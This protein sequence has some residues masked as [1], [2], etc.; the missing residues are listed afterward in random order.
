MSSNNT[1]T[2]VQIVAQRLAEIGDTFEQE[3]FA[4]KL[5]LPRRAR[6]RA[7][8]E[9][10]GP[11]GAVSRRRPWPDAALLAWHVGMLLYLMHR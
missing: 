6:R 4:K 10:S 8:V 2:D 9:V 3:F 7:A 11:A 5:D 1:E